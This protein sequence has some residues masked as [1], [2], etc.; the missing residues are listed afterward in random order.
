M[1]VNRQKNDYDTHSCRWMV[2]FVRAVVMTQRACKIHI[3]SCS[4]RIVMYSQGHV[5]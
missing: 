2:E 4:V 5:C 1:Q 3:K